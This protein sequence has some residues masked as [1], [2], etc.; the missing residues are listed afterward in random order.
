MKA[1]VDYPGVG[2]GVMVR[3]ANGDFLFGLRTEN[4]KNEPNKWCFPGGAL[5]F[6]EKLFDCAVREAKEE[7]GIVVEP[8]RLVKVIDHIIPAEKQHWVNPIIEARIVSGEPKVMEPHKMCKWQWFSLSNLPKTMTSNM[9]FL[10]SEI[11]AGKIKI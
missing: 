10:F 1:G 9:V 8:I 2:V 11:L 3:N 7:A 4:S 5:N 6:G